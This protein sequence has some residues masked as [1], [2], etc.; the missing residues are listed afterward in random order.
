MLLIALVILYNVKNVC[1]G[2]LKV[3]RS[4][5][6]D[7]GKVLIGFDNTIFFK[8]IAQFCPYSE[9]EISEKVSIHTEL[10]RAFDLGRVSPS[11]FYNQ[12][13]K[14]LK[15]EIEYDEFY[16][17]YNDI[18][19]LNESAVKI[20]SQLKPNFRMVLL[21]NT[22]IMRFGFVR[23]KFPEV[24]FFDAYVLSYEEGRMKPDP[25]I[26]KAALKKAQAQAHDCVFIDDREE[27]V[28][29]ATKIGIHIIHYSDHTDLETEFRNLGLI[30]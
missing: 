7:L 29:A 20:M 25:W 10:V 16:R 8:K 27:N 6:S 18:F 17:I 30:V 14:I 28:Q 13:V 2:T 9:R 1:Q 22:D 19:S 24:F 12:A 3:I 4:V 5:I 23:K 11:E 26:F 15:A 21:S